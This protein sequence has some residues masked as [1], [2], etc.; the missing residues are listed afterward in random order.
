MLATPQPASKMTGGP[1][2]VPTDLRKTAHGPSRTLKSGPRR[3]PRASPSTL[4][5]T[6][7]SP[8]ELPGAAKKKICKR[9]QREHQLQPSSWSTL[10]T[11]SH[12]APTVDSTMFRRSLIVVLACPFSRASPRAGPWGSA[13]ST[14]LRPL[15]P[16]TK[17]DLADRNMRMARSD[18][19][20]EYLDEE[21]NPDE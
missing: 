10:N 9:L 15:P 8:E 18:F 19:A 1:G 4:R 21:F 6:I 20:C 12:P 3:A 17:E 7:G 13:D 2:N 5:A 11:L 16:T 14:G